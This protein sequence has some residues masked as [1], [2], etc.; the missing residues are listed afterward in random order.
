MHIDCFSPPKAGIME[1]HF[2]ILQFDL[3]DAALSTEDW[4]YENTEGHTEKELFRL[5]PE[6][7]KTLAYVNFN[8]WGLLVTKFFWIYSLFL[9]M[10]LRMY[11][12]YERIQLGVELSSLTIATCHIEFKGSLVVLF[13]FLLG[14]TWF[15]IASKMISVSEIN[16][17][18][19]ESAFTYLPFSYLLSII[20][21]WYKQYCLS[22]FKYR[23][24]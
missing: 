20:C 19:H 24:N 15:W 9:K 6:L 22:L 5:F 7:E 1:R 3:T 2:S 16:H 17:Q 18:R 8:G 10:G 11:I 13:R 4:I 23:D 21:F 14:M 12:E